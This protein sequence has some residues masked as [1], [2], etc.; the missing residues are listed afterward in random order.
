MT[1]KPRLFLDAS[2]LIAAAGSEQGGSSL[3]LAICRENKAQAV[4]SRIV[5]LEAERNIREKLGGDALLR[6]YQQVANLDLELVSP[7]TPGECEAQARIIN[8][9]DAHVL[10]A[11]VKG[12][13]DVLLTL[14]RKHFF[15]RQVRDAGLPFA[16]MTP[17][18][19]LR[20]LI[21]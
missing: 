14:D 7:P 16:I 17:G 3:I 2:V 5:L 8:A 15:T 10:A 20:R 4:G 6:Y 13:V 19:Y 21:R 9:K 11:A 1:G 12:R 18:D